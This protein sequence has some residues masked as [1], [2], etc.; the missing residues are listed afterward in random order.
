METI[1]NGTRIGVIGVGQ[2]GGAALK[3]WQEAGAEVTGFGKDDDLAALED[4][5][6]VAFAYRPQTFDAVG[7]NLKGRLSERQIAVSFMA[8]KTACQMSEVLGTSRIV[9]TMTNFNLL[10]GE[11]MTAWYA[12][13][14]VLTEEEEA[15]IGSLLSCFG[16]CMRLKSEQSFNAYTTSGA[17]CIPALLAHVMAL[18]QWSLQMNGFSM[19]DA[20][21]I[22]DQTIIGTAATFRSGVSAED[23]ERG[24][25]TEG[26]ATW[27]M[28]NKLNELGWDGALLVALEAARLRCEELGNKS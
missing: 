7:A 10:V 28:F 1:L 23:L 12:D 25:T 9:R 2:I 4:V 6:I 21:T 8:G 18:S 22:A 19:E 14:G 15:K 27:E 11:A 24:V 20:R 26:G 17:G 13:E 3:Q 16:K 5:D